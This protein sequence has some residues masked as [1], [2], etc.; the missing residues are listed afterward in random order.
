MTL[1]S[2]DSAPANSSVSEIRTCESTALVLL[3]FDGI[4]PMDGVWKLEVIGLG[5]MVRICSWMRL[6]LRRLGITTRLRKIHN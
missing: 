5:R 6:Q 4:A 3:G 2:H 1:W